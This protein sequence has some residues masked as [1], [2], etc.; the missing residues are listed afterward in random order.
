M[1][2]R[3]YQLRQRADGQARTR[4]RIIEAAID[5]HATVGPARATVTEIAKKAGVERVTVY[6]H[7]PDETSLLGACSA[8]YRSLNPPPDLESFRSIADPGERLRSALTEL[9]DYYGRVAPMLRNVLR[10]AEAEPSV[11]E[12]TAP[13]R[14]YVADLRD[15]LARGWSARGRR[16][17][18]LLG[19]LTLALDF[20]TW[21]RLVGDETVP[22]EDAV[23][24]MAGLVRQSI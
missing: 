20:H 11:W 16:R 9:Y 2:A 22:H 10:D 15:M 4:Q 14:R 5:M 17:R 21:Q 24:M 1:A 3:R 6:R 18:L 8:H 12:A 19:A 13:R 23:E 7:F